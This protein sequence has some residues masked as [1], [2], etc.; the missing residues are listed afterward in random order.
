M[1]TQDIKPTAIAH[2]SPVRG[3]HIVV[4][5][6]SSGMG[7]ATAR[8]AL[9]AGATATLVSRSQERLE[10]ARGVL[11]AAAAIRALDMRR[12]DD[13]A[14]L[15]AELPPF[16]HL[17]ISAG[18]MTDGVGPFLALPVASARAQVESRFW[19]PYLAARYGA[20]KIRDGG[21]ITFFTGVIG[22]KVIPGAS[23]PAAVHGALEGLARILAVELAPTRVNVVSPGTIETPLHGW[24]PDDQRAA[25]FDGA[26]M[27]TTARRVGQPEE[28]GHAVLSLLE[29]PYI[30]GITL[31]VNGG[32]AL[33]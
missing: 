29:N 10:A 7:L 14:R 21:S 12:E 23:V 8:A 4:V 16:D 5:G 27:A 2:G 1:D 3:Q 19:G 17:V 30:T 9:A 22:E 26:A 6:G 32:A 24:M 25:F 18:E 31:P 15:F 13:V 33:L 28:I 20:A 11:G